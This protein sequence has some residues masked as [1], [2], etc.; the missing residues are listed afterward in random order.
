MPAVP[1][2]LTEAA[3]NWFYRLEPEMVDSFD[4][5]KQIFLNHFM[6]QTDRLYSTDDLYT[7]RQREDEPLREYAEHFSHEYS[8]CPETVDRAAYDAFKS[9]LRSLHFWYL[10]HSS[11]WRTYDE[12]MKQ[13]II[14]AKV[15]YFNS[16]S[17]PLARQEEPT[18]K[19]Y[20]AQRQPYTP[21]ERTDGYPATGLMNEQEI[22]PKL[23]NR[24]P[25]RQDNRDTEKFYQYHQHNNHNTKE[26]ISLRKIVEHLI[27]EGKLDQYIARPPQ[28]PAPKVNRQI[29]MISTISGVPTLAGI[30][31]WSR[32][33]YVRATQ[34]PQV[35]GIEVNRHHKAPRVTWEPITFCEKEEERILYPYYDPMIIRVEDTD[36]DVE[37]VLINT[38]SLVNVIFANAFRELGIN[39]GYINLQLTPLLSFSGNLVQPVGSFSLHIAFGISP[40]RTMRYDHFLIVDCLI[41]Y[42]IIIGQTTLTG[43]KAHLSPHML[44]MKFPTSFGMGA[45]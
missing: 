16:K 41:A 32:K 20:S 17:G 22:I 38:E 33:Q 15:E 11:N 34:Y 37:W 25:N 18:L 45:V 19:N 35:F 28:A 12:L 6:I 30:S 3:L 7:V 26:C 31:N 8:R 40:R 14:Y 10:V 23:V 1:S 13:A 2:A 5:L 21:I 27:Q 4:E 36:F 43:I 42:N 44:L 39:D 9:G 29:N 24:K